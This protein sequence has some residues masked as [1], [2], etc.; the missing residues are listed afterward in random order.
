MSKIIKKLFK[1]VFYIYGYAVVRPGKVKSASSFGLFREVTD[2]L[3]SKAPVPLSVE[4]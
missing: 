3:G 4:G 2:K 1:N